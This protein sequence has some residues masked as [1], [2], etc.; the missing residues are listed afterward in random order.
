VSPRAL[1]I[2]L[3]FLFLL[4]IASAANAADEKRPNVLFIAV[5]DLRV[6]LGCYGDTLVKSPNI[7]KLAARG[8]LFNRAYC[9]QAVCNPSR[10]SLLTGLRPDT[11]GVW[12]L[13]THFRTQRPDAVTLPQC[14]MQQGYFSQCVGKI[15]HNWRQDDYKGDPTSWSVPS[16][17]HYANHGQD[18]PQ[19]DGEVPPSKS[20]TPKTERCDVP[21][22]AY[23]DGRIADLAVKALAENARAG[24]KDRP[25]FL[26]VGFWKPHSPFNAPAK[27]WDLYRRSDVSPP[28][29]PDA[30]QGVPQ[31]ALHDSREIL[32]A[33]KKRPGGRPTPAE[34]LALR[35]GYYAAISYLDAQVGKVLDALDRQGLRDNTI[36]VFWSDHGYHLGEQT[37]WAKTSNFELDAR[38]P[39][40][41]TT[42][43]RAGGQKTDALVELLDLYPTLADLC[44]LE[45]PEELEGRSLRPVLDDPAATVKD[46]A[47]TQHT[48][49]A[50]PSEDEPL[51][52]MGYSMRTDRYRYA[53]WRKVDGG[54]V[55]ARELYDH[56]EDPAETVN[57]AGESA[58]AKLIE[59][60]AGQLTSVIDQK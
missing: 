39:L 59:Q 34:T 46:T 50:Y 41:I 26:A 10:A 36:V 31:I 47:I 18:K 35:H 54:E 22:E 17:M 28:E 58:N 30:P 29:H 8:T 3:S 60:L 12:D 9:Q 16:V 37:L 5:D 1:G 49:P 51:A 15:F 25:F 43:D 23:F 32:G 2:R 55:V 19:V 4:A 57:L 11:L 48:R 44:G 33:F 45:A 52:V 14:F 27:Y 20:K 38:V 6:E 21:D 7:D 24:N 13:P 42:P 53:E 40:I 56:R